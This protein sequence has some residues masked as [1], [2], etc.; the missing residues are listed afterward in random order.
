MLDKMFLPICNFPGKTREETLVLKE[1]PLNIDLIP[2]VIRQAI[3]GSLS[4]KDDP[5]EILRAPVQTIDSYLD[6]WICVYIDRSSIRRT[7]KAGYGVLIHC[8]L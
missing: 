3:K 4:K 7:P 2:P 8:I 5:T 6:K 1:T